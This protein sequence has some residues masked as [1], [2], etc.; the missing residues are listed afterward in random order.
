[1]T[2]IKEFFDKN[3]WTLT[4]VLWDELTKDEVLPKNLAI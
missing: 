3:T 1:M 4:Y 2:Q